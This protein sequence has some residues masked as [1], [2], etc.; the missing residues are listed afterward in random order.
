[1][2]LNRSYGAII[3]SVVAA[4]FAV[5]CT[6]AVVQPQEVPQNTQAV[7]AAQQAR[8]TVEGMTCASCNVAVKVAAEK[9]NGVS[10]AGASHAK[11][12]AWAM[13]DPVKTNPEA[14]A[15]AITNA[16]YKTT[17]VQ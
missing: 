4:T 5:S 11:K 9:V 15:Q 3:L 1:M 16:G 17:V 12:T 6:N 13:Y 10:K 8:F 14:I 2:K 7:A